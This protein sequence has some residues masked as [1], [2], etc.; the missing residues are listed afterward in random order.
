MN[1]AKTHLIPSTFVSRL[2]SWVRKR[3][4]DA[5]ML[6]HRFELPAASERQPFV[7]VPLATI[8]ALG[9]AAAEATRDPFAGLHSAELGRADMLDVLAFACSGV[10]NLGEALERYVQYVAP[11]H[12][13]MVISMHPSPRGAILRQI[14]P[15][16]PDC[17]GRHANE[18]WTAAVL[19]AARRMAARDW[20]PLRI[21]LAHAAPRDNRELVRVF[22]TTE[23]VFDAGMNAIEVDRSVLA[24]PVHLR[25]PHEAVVLKRYVARAPTAPSDVSD[26]QFQV[27]AA[28]QDRLSGGPPLILDIA[29][30]VRV[31]ARTLQRRLTEEGMSFQQVLDDV[32]RDVSVRHVER[33]ELPLAAIA[34]MVGYSQQSAFFR[35]FRRWTGTT[36]GRLRQDPRA[37]DAAGRGASRSN[38]EGTSSGAANRRSW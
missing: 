16:L 20:Q 15:G 29:R 34:E 23:I 19:V 6:L 14:I 3:G 28:I 26:F 9:E 37:P 30:A 24:Y 27:R 22:G 35:S 8:V 31:S 38:T 32:R 33:G 18:H 25:P 17:Q 1:P 36:P 10:A 11:V 2:V 4:G 21:W 12:D 5:D 7:V 13:I